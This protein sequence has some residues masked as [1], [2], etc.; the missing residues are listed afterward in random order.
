MITITID[1]TKLTE[2]YLQADSVQE[3][4]RI[5]NITKTILNVKNSIG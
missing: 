1:N 3:M 5:K 4:D 2:N